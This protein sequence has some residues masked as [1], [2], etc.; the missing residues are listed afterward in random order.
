MF[1]LYRHLSDD[2]LVKRACNG[3]Q[4][5]FGELYSRYMTP[6][7]RYVYYRTNNAEDAEDLTETIFIKAWEA[8]PNLQ[9]KDPNFK[10]WIYRIARN[11][12]ID[13]YRA[14][15]QDVPLESQE[16]LVDGEGDPLQAIENSEGTD[17]VFQLVSRLEPDMQDVIVYR[18]LL[19]L[20]HNETAKAMNRSVVYIRVLQHRALKKLR[21]L[22]KREV[23]ENE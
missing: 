11:A 2:E 5:A 10:A 22:I 4:D 1:F 18:F 19:G 12:I 6:I 20:S 8:L 23:A 16:N 17:A 15:R 7:Y 13:K 21:D 14:N 3:S 9:A